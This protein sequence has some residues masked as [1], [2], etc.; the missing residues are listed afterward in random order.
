MNIVGFCEVTIDET[1]AAAL[2]NLYLLMPYRAAKI[3]KFFFINKKI[4][5]K[6]AFVKY[7]S[8]HTNEF[9]KIK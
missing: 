5:H 9:L 6:L 4:V 1:I 3:G 8:V 2:F 7:L